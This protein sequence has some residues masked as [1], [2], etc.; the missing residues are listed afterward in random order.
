MEL[1][2]IEIWSDVLY[3]LNHQQIVF[4]IQKGKTTFFAKIE[5]KIRVNNEYS[6][7]IMSEQEFEELFKN[8]IF[9]LYEK[10]SGEDFI[11]KE[12]DDEYYS[13]WHK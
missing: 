8:E 9:Y 5:E 3:Y 1:Q 4:V 11:S 12:K 10:E 13:W 6:N 7:Y 2:Q